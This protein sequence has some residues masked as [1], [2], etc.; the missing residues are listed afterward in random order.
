MIIDTL[1]NSI[2]YTSLHPH[3][4][5]AFDY[6]RQFDGSAAIG[7]HELDADRCF[8]LV[9]TYQ[10]KPE[11]E[12]LFEAHRK[13]IDVQYLHTGRE[14]MLW[15]PLATM[16]EQTMDYDEAKDAALW[17]LHATTTAVRVSAGDFVIFYPQDAHAP[18]VHWDGMDNV[19]KVVVKVAVQ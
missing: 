11:T 16:R 12:A 17:K 2:H 8:A 10:T 6:L 15:A 5:L 19:L 4:A 9:Q 7:R 13:Y 14:S 3:F 18:C 1:E